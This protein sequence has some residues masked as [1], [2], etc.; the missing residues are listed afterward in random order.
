MGIGIGGRCVVMTE[1]RGKTRCRW[2]MAWLMAREI[3]DV[4][5][6]RGSDGAG[7][8]CGGLINCVRRCR[9][10]AALLI[11]V[12]MVGV[13]FSA[14]RCSCVDVLVGIAMVER[15]R[16]VLRVILIVLS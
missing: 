8:M 7:Q 14:R 3:E 12:A 11:A 10:E 16:C 9:D 15:M 2:L 1:A 13:W 4:E 6:M 5:G